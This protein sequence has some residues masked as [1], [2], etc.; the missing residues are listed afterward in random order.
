MS[1]TIIELARWDKDN[2]EAKKL[3]ASPLVRE[4]LWY[5]TKVENPQTWDQPFSE[6]LWLIAWWLT[7]PFTATVWTLASMF[8]WESL[9][10]AGKRTLAGIWADYQTQDKAEQF[11]TSQML[12]KYLNEY[13]W[14]FD[15]FPVA[16]DLFGVWAKAIARKATWKTTSAM[17]QTGK[18]I[19]KSIDWAWSNLTKVIEQDKTLAKMLSDAKIWAHNRTI[20]NVLDLAKENPMASKRIFEWLWRL[21]PANVKKYWEAFE[22]IQNSY[23]YSKLPKY[24]LSDAVKSFYSMT[25]GSA[26]FMG[27]MAWAQTLTEAVGSATDNEKIKQAWKLF[28]DPI[29]TTLH[30]FGA[31][32]NMFIDDTYKEFASKYWYTVEELKWLPDDDP[33]KQDIL[34]SADLWYNNTTFSQMLW[35]KPDSV[36][37]KSL[38]AITDTV[39]SALWVKWHMYWLNKWMKKIRWA[40]TSY[41]SPFD[42]QWNVTIASMR[43]V[44]EAIK[45]AKTQEERLMIANNAVKELWDK[46]LKW[47]DLSIQE[48]IQYW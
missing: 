36:L 24:K 48:S 4:Y 34:K 41:F 27:W 13:W 15:F 30:L 5:R 3:L 25:P 45:E 29:N 19:F 8:W 38:A 11:S 23:K 47:K 46:L 43:K 33:L 21:D 40:W 1:Q 37:W 32:K 17:L 14:W 26:M 22:A 18:K 10:K 39:V 44:E 31:N 42:K 7:S 20:E 28:M 35:W 6:K 12:G 9:S 2:P 16:S